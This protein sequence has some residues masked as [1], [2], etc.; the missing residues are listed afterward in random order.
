M[1]QQHLWRRSG[2]LPTLG[3]SG[4]IIMDYVYDSK[5][6]VKFLTKYWKTSRKVKTYSEKMQCPHCMEWTKL[7]MW[8]MG[9]EVCDYCDDR[10]PML[11]CYHCTEEFDKN[12]ANVFLIE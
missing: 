4:V 8:N 9:M 7:T 6:V 12:Y 10:H 11:R 3:N 1:M 2:H 5:D